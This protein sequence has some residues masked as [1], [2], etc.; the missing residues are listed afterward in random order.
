VKTPKTTVH[1][2]F[3]PELNEL[4]DATS[5]YLGT[6]KTALVE[7]CIRLNLDKAIKAGEAKRAVAAAK[8]KKI[9]ANT[10]LD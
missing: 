7:E 10:K 2:R 8:F 3:T 9:R 5:D 4:L 1:F 6:T